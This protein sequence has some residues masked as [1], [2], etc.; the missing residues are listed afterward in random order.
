MTAPRPVII[1]SGG[2]NLASL[3][4]ALSRLEREVPVTSDPA[5]IQGATHVILPGVGAAQDAMTRLNA[6][7][8][9]QVIRELER[10]VLGIC[11]GMQL[12]FSSSEE[13]NAT[14][15]GIIE[16]RAVR[17]PD[18]PGLPVPQMGW[19]E[20]EVRMPCPLLEGIG[21]GSYAYFVHSYGLPV[22]DYTLAT[23]DYGGPVSAVVGKG[24]F[25]GTQFHP[26]R[27]AQV[28]ARILGNFLDLPWN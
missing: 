22:G 3:T 24:N 11:L 1:N 8:L 5:E 26:E 23:T 14:C 2:A 28:G 25:F 4:F 13:D 10:P 16:G 21:A 27:S 6:L 12:L 18:R 19:N 20:L 7:G 15:L 17:F 9:D